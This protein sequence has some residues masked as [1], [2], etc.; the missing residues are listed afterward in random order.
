MFACGGKEDVTLSAALYNP[1]GP[2]A[3]RVDCPALTL[4]ASLVSRNGGAA[5]H[6]PCKGKTNPR[7]CRGQLRAIV[8]LIQVAG[9]L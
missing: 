2:R 6:P 9:H 4:G 5:P 8:I 1:I 3:R 7:V